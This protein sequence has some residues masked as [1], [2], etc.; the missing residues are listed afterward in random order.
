[1]TNRSHH[2]VLVLV[3]TIFVVLGSLPL[4]AIGTAVA[5]E[6]G[7]PPVPNPTDTL[8]DDSLFRGTDDGQVVVWERAF[9]PLR[10]NDTNA[11]T[12]VPLPNILQLQT[13]EEG[14]EFTD[15]DDGVG[16]ASLVAE[17]NNERNP[18]G[19]HDTGNVTISYDADRSGVG[20]TLGEED[21]VDFIAARLT[22]SG[23]GFPEDYGDAV[24]NLFGSIDAAN[25]NATFEVID[26]DVTLSGT[27]EKQHDFDGSGQYVV[28]AVVNNGTQDGFQISD[29]GE[30]TSVDGTV[31]LVGADMVSVQQ[32]PAEVS[33]PDSA[34]AGENLT[35]Q[36]NTGNAYDANQDG[37]MT[38]VVA[39]YKKDTFEDSRFDLVVNESELGPEFDLNEDSQI[40]HS[41]G[42]AEG[43]ADVEDGITIN[44]VELSDG[45]VTRS[46]GLG[47]IIDR[48]AEDL[49]TTSPVTD[50]L[51]NA[52]T[53]NA[54]VTG[55]TNEDRDATVTVETQSGFD[56][57]TYQYIV[58][59][60]P[61]NNASSL[62]TD[63][64][65]VDLSEP[66][67]EAGPRI[68]Q[69]SLNDDPVAVGEEVR[70][71]VTV[72]NPTDASIT[73]TIT[74]SQ[75]DAT[76]DSG[77][78]FVPADSF[79]TITLSETFSTEGSRTLTISGDQAD[80]QDVT[81]SVLPPAER[82]FSVSP[83]TVEVGNRV[84]VE[85]RVQN[86][87]RTS[88]TIPVEVTGLPEGADNTANV[89]LDAESADNITFPFTPQ[90]AGELSIS[91]NESSETQTVT[92]EPETVN[93]RVSA[94]PSE[95]EPGQNVTFEVR[96]SDT[97]ALVDNVDLGFERTD[98]DDEV[99][100]SSGVDAPFVRSFNDP[101]AYRVTAT[102][103]NGDTD[104][105]AGSTEFEVLQPANLSLE[106]TSTPFNTVIASTNVQA[107]ATIR[108]AGEIPGTQR[109]QLVATDNGE[110]IID[111]I[112]VS[113]GPEGSESVIL[114]GPLGP[115]GTSLPENRTL[116]VRR[117]ASDGS[118]QNQSEIGEVEVT[119]ALRQTGV[120]IEAQTVEEDSP[121]RVN[122]TVTN[123]GTD[124][125]D[126]ELAS[127][128]IAL[129]LSGQGVDNK[130]I[131]K[132]FSPDTGNS[133]TLTYNFSEGY[134]VNDD[135]SLDLTID[136]EF[137]ESNTTFTNV[138]NVTTSEVYNVRLTADDDSVQSGEEVSFDVT[139]A[140]L[141][142][143]EPSG[144]LEATLEILNADGQV[145]D[146]T[147]TQNG[148]ATY[149]FENAGTYFVR[150][151]DHE[152]TGAS[153]GV[154]DAGRT[155]I[156]VLEPGDV[157]VVGAS[158]ATPEVARTESATITATVA[159]QGDT[160]ATETISLSNR[161]NPGASESVTL[162]GG[163]RKIVELTTN[164]TETGSYTLE[165]QEEDTGDTI[166]AGQVE[167]TEA[168]VVT[169]IRASDRS[170][171]VDESVDITVEVTN[172]G[173]VQ[174]NDSEL[175]R[176]LTLS[177]TSATAPSEELS[178]SAFD[179]NPTY[180]ASETHTLTFSPDT[181]NP[182]NES[183]V[184][185]IAVDDVDGPTVSV[186]RQRADL[187]LDVSPSG[188]LT[189]GEEI[190]FT[191][192]A[193]G[194]NV[195]ATIQIPNRPSIT[196]GSDG[197][198]TE[199]FDT[200]FSG[201][202]R[203]TKDSNRTTYFTDANQF[204]SVT[205][206]A[207]LVVTS[208]SVDTSQAFAGQTASVDVTVAN[209]G[210]TEGTRTVALDDAGDVNQT[211]TLTA[212]ER[213][214]FTLTPELNQVGT[215]SLSV[216]GTAAGTV[217][218]DEA[219][220]IT[221]TEVESAANPEEEFTVNV[222]VTDRVA[223]SETGS[224]D[225]VTVTV[226]EGE[227]EQSETV[228]TIEP[229]DGSSTTESFT[230]TFDTTGT[231]PVAIE[232]GETD[233]TQI[234]DV[235]IARNTVPLALNV[236][237]DPAEVPIG[238]S[239]T[240]TVDNASSGNSIEATVSVAG[241][242][243]STGDDGTVQTTIPVSGNFTATATKAGTAATGY[244]SDSQPVNVTDSI[245][246]TISSDFGSVPADPAQGANRPSAATQTRTVTI[247]NTGGRAI[248][249]SG[250]GFTG[251]NA[252][253]YR[254]TSS[255][256]TSV[257]AN[258][259]ETVVVAFE[260]TIRD[261]SSATLR[262]RTDTPQNSVR[263]LGLGGTGVGPNVSVSTTSLE[264]GDDLSETGLPVDRTVT[265]SNDGNAPLSVDPGSVEAAFSVNKGSTTIQHGN[266]EDYTVTF[267]PQE[268]PGAFGDV[269]QFETNDTFDETVGVSLTGTVSQGELQLSTGSFN[270]GELADGEST[271]VDV[272]VTN[273]GTEE[274]NNVTAGLG[275]T[276]GGLSV[277]APS[278]GEEVVQ[279][280]APGEQEL[281]E[282]QVT[283]DG[284]AATSSAGIQ[285]DPS[286]EG[287]T[288]QTVTVSATPTAPSLNVQPDPSTDDL[289][290]G[291][292]ALGSTS[293]QVVT[294]SNTGGAE[295]Q[296]TNISIDGPTATPFSLTG[297][298]STVTISPGE[299]RA[300]SVQFNPQTAGTFEDS[301]DLEFDWNNASEDGT[302]G[303]SLGIRGTGTETNLVGNT[304]S[305]SFGTTGDGSTVADAVTI[306]NDGNDQL[307]VESVSL[308]GQSPNQF[309]SGSAPS[310]LDAGES[311]TIPVRYTPTRAADHTAVLTITASG[312]D[313]FSSFKATLRGTAT[314]P[315]VE[316]NDTSLEFGFV[317]RQLGTP[318]TE[319][320]LIT[321]AGRET[322]TL[323]INDVSVSGNDAFTL[324]G[325]PS[326]AGDA[327][328][329]GFN[330]DAGDSGGLTGTL[331][332][333]TNDP[334]E[335]SIDVPLAGVAT[336]PDA[337]VNR[338]SIAFGDVRADTTSA[339]EGVEITNVGGAPVNVTSTS[340]ASTAQFE[341]TSGFTGTLVPGETATVSVR[342]A[343]TNAGAKSTTLAV[344]TNRTND[345]T[346]ITLTATGVTSDA[347]VTS[348]LSGD[349]GEIGSSSS[350]IQTITVRNDG[351][352]EL[353]LDNITASGD[354]YRVLGSQQR[355][356]LSQ[357]ERTDISVAFS[358]TA[359]GE[360]FDGTLSIDTN[361]GETGTLTRSL[362]GTGGEANATVSQSAVDFG[363]VGVE[364]SD[365]TELT[366]T[367]DGTSQ[368]NVT[369]VTISGADASAFDVS[370]LGTPSLGVDESETF[371]VTVSPT[372][373][374][375]LSGQL[376]ITT[377][378]GTSSVSLGATGV[379]PELEVSRQQV[380]FDRT[381]LGTTST[382]TVEIRNT[383][384]LPL[385]VQDILL[386]TSS[387]G[388]FSVSTDDAVI[389]AKSSREVTVRFSP[390]TTDVQ[391]AKDGTQRT[392]TLTLRSN[393]TDQ[394]SLD[395]G[396]TARSKTP[397]L[398]IANV[399]RFGTL[400]VGQE[401]TRTLEVSNQPSASADIT[402]D[403]LTLIG[404][405]NNEF[406]VTPPV[407]RTLEPGDSKEIDVSVTPQTGGIKTAS[408]LVTTNDA[409]Q[410]RQSVSLSNS[411]TVVLVRY[412]SVTFD[413]NGVT[414][415]DPKFK[416]SNDPDTGIAGIDPRLN[417]V[418]SD[419]T[420]EFSTRSAASGSELESSRP[421]EP[422]RYLDIATTNLD[423]SQHDETT[424]EFR[425]EKS[426]IKSLSA[427]ENS[428]ALYQYNG[429]GYEAL[430]TT[431][432]PGSDTASAYAYSA[433][434]DSF[435]DLAIG[436]GQPKLG[437]VTGTASASNVPDTLESGQSADVTITADIQNIGSISGSDTFEVVDSSGSVLNS[438][439]VN[440]G[441]NTRTT[442]T[443]TVTLTGAGSRTL[444][445]QG[446]G[447]SQDV[448]ID[449]NSPSSGPSGPSGGDD[450][451][452]D[453]VRQ[454][455]APARV[456]SQ[457]DADGRATA[458]L[459]DGVSVSQVQLTIP[460]ATGETTVEELTN[461]PEGVP[462]PTRQ[463]IG[464]VDITAPDPTDG[465][466]TVRISVRSS[467]LPAGS[468]PDE[469]TISHYINGEWRDLD[470][471]VVSSNG[472]VVLEA[473]TDSFSPFAVTYQQQTA[474]PEPDTATPEPEP[475]T[476]T[477][478]PD[479]ATP[480]PD[481]P[482]QVE[483]PTPEPD[484]DGFTGIFIVV[485]LLAVLIAV[486]AYWYQQNN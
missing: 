314:P 93:L 106:S 171:L 342:A 159:N 404:R 419:F 321:N 412:G 452:D 204:V 192:Q 90:T 35:F 311:T 48:L 245:N 142:V 438:T 59:S 8:E 290:F 55:V 397:D 210:G 367:N 200:P 89:T 71:T 445:V 64:G 369:G 168:L 86:N 25:E 437:V 126:S 7:T 257:P 338:S 75:D 460:G 219:V 322:T 235:T 74:L 447:T 272:V 135:T 298:P 319:S 22:G 390:P 378:Q 480:E 44:G 184:R 414:S 52:E 109:L 233:P 226:G 283:Q 186:S 375:S 247:N 354:A 256:P 154:F 134:S 265:V 255:I 195:D 333:E 388:Q 77:E 5:Q 387:P 225:D 472:E 37:E 26:E 252:D 11:A 477:P 111:D 237:P 113:I 78:V 122:V 440:L 458:D 250:F 364:A 286:G 417:S 108:N 349:F 300:I 223:D 180:N 54:S 359:Q 430:S 176:E 232:T 356:T 476:A 240:F 420:M 10:S 194:E 155:T 150:T 292:V 266:S 18:A 164:F 148:Q 243:L 410:S 334:D 451:D 132:T 167:V 130:T 124:S 432:V 23:D 216:N 385:N 162:A 185:N 271:T 51:D 1:M 119:S 50:P 262:F 96:R 20:N 405:N 107:R 328:V 352:A 175:T 347:T 169:D 251:S 112:N 467:A 316:L 116:E 179:G 407:E 486:G 190:T 308:G 461:L 99:T 436:A 463:R 105:V 302:T 275:T 217:T 339:T 76:L 165:V 481:T 287:T 196:T 160:E 473:Q 450:D 222:T 254:F 365:S 16:G 29:N 94:T 294:V 350:A 455:D 91:L 484:D 318:A 46:V 236:D 431:R 278:D 242:T 88:A 409:R 395:I 218:V 360:T 267:D 263:R 279:N 343:P 381:R 82:T 261:S 280:L 161:E 303:V 478:E 324:E 205:E 315:E 81:V 70:A 41:I 201:F 123:R 433:T 384:N 413:Y 297:V 68:S 170:P 128:N 383:G 295:L 244:R 377:E 426:T 140:D 208:A 114:T 202:V 84:E 103:S 73:E 344:T 80:A 227:D 231:R 246:V 31:A 293:T 469:L 249:V 310:T 118:T 228:A 398:Q 85:V 177:V 466:A 424:V 183:G 363:G 209:T 423:A 483:S 291:G 187:T 362:T 197:T 348:D 337:T 258:S 146:T 253:Q 151:A 166:T 188:D 182:A 72:T 224:V 326:Q 444:T 485:L 442:V 281:V 120:A 435:N 131:E 17:F 391:A 27:Y 63:T 427:T 61:A 346:P 206:P 468:S 136:E 67:E 462:E 331:T 284:D 6:N 406:S 178:K 418:V 464:T 239:V 100:N 138:I 341:L 306:T 24:T 212:G 230:F 301:T 60:K 434:I 336:A 368:L 143:T 443:F 87:R 19:V 370:G 471:T 288:Q 259:E 38:H 260:P 95:A 40:E 221:G 69:I 238:E 33:A 98:S 269:L 285:F 57:G 446:A 144:D 329:V 323:S 4:G 14:Q 66:V 454:P 101:G 366:L 474:T 327:A 305:I 79:R 408:L 174:V 386:G 401:T 92:V 453:D 193:D 199:T 117:V 43:V 482:D 312:A 389:P 332:I 264:F 104:Y 470:T 400:Q 376:T 270:V 403:T 459:T 456:T 304:S 313:G 317:N 141:D 172:E 203:A 2:R 97:N 102:K 380:T 163:E 115:T 53:I 268:T 127:Q 13:L 32:G 429:T 396:V 28:Y 479:T 214:S 15:G 49:N 358:P 457:I 158:V 273:T 282:I 428:I 121:I 335:P 351:G 198:A 325:T 277:S 181:L 207:N 276:S 149:T 309:A 213:Q 45:R 353:I 137:V 9:L 189:T 56:N 448:S 125:L 425:V 173:T 475:G 156:S 393:D 36:V 355:I 34:S 439:T 42:N 361:D 289:R 62:S 402:L 47:A 211:V 3:V 215:R 399:V 382:E 234:G 411:R 133:S 374:Q 345:V 394:N 129:T 340:L 145:V 449:I 296:L 220:V 241:R 12:Q 153:G 139:S 274:I 152:A 441:A 248:A 416:A 379:E 392:A 372:V 373:A 83:T 65:T 422:V 191:T 110:E 229:D 330:P 157:Q 357:S 58:V 30:I 421:V 320:V 415:Q 465:T 39:V 371:T 21:N 299:Q 147:D 307:T